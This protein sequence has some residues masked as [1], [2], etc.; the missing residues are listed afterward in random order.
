[1]L[2]F[3]GRLRPNIQWNPDG[4]LEVRFNRPINADGVTLI[5]KELDT[6]RDSSNRQISEGSQDDL[7][8]TFTGR[9]RNRRFQTETHNNQSSDA[10]LPTI[11]IKFEGSD[12]VYT[13]PVISEPDEVEGTNWEIVFAV[14]Y[15]GQEDYTSPVSFIPRARGRLLV[16]DNTIDDGLRNYEGHANLTRHRFVSCNM[17]GKIIRG[18]RS[19]SSIAHYNAADTTDYP[20]G[21]DHRVFTRQAGDFDYVYFNCHGDVEL[22]GLLAGQ[23]YA[24]CMICNDRF[25]HQ[26]FTTCTRYNAC[27]AT[28]RG[29][30]FYRLR[31][32]NNARIRVT[33]S[34]TPADLAFTVS[35]S[36]RE[37]ITGSFVEWEE[38]EQAFANA[39]TGNPDMTFNLGP[40]QTCQIVVPN[41]YEFP[42]LLAF[43]T[44][45]L[46]P[47]FRMDNLPQDP[48]SP[49]LHHSSAEDV[50][51]DP[52]ICFAG[53]GGPL[54][55]TEVNAT[56]TATPGA[57]PG[58]FV[59]GSCPF[60]S[61][62]SGLR[63]IALNRA[64][65]LQWDDVQDAETYTLYWSTTP[66]VQE[67]TANAIKDIGSASY[68]HTGLTNGR[69]YYYRV[70][71][72]KGGGDLTL[73]CWGTAGNLSRIKIM[74]AGCCLTGRKTVFADAA[75]AA[76][77]KFFIGHQVVTADASENL[78]NAFWQR[79]LGNGAIL[80]NV[81]HIYNQLTQSNASYRRT[82]PVIYYRDTANQT[83]FWRPGETPPDPANIKLE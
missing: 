18:T 73:D 10:S 60:T 69:T 57:P 37:E 46:R 35:L 6:Y 25:R 7:L 75:L 45:P 68:R 4:H 20:G 78:I 33:G 82:R 8:A 29:Y 23:Q 55:T 28:N 56:P 26:R 32:N 14:Q 30:F 13:I 34:I 76:G 38:Y 19:R 64:V 5:I 3:R 11:R 9:I 39:N 74:Y 77:V 16:V 42:S 41:A 27:M 48:P 21:F 81:I 54:S 12:D 72:R 67:N 70:R 24:S 71:A 47:D 49:Y 44:T 36:D 66:G 40:P 15:P 31:T 80:R 63:A 1:M 58:A 61:P 17:E 53:E 22:V 79:W 62:P 65:D 51:G 50:P 52:V 2:I 59:S 83:Q 43:P